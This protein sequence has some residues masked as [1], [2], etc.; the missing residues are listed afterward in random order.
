MSRLHRYRERLM[1]DT[2]PH[3]LRCTTHEAFV[4][5]CPTIGGDCDKYDNHVVLWVM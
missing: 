3:L 2:Q 4:C 1:L 5:V